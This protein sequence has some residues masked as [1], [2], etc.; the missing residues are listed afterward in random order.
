M[1][2]K[3]G[4]LKK[5]RR[6]LNL[7]LRNLRK[8]GILRAMGKKLLRGREEDRNILGREMKNNKLIRKGRESI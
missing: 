4:D 8:F 5:V 2:R 6:K 7:V 1:L 3:E